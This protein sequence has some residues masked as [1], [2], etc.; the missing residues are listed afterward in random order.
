[1]IYDSDISDLKR[2]KTKVPLAIAYDYIIPLLFP[3]Q[4]DPIDEL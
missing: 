3:F 4:I 2:Q 1:M